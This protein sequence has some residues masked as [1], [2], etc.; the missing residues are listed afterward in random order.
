[1]NQG[2]LLGDG[3]ERKRLG[4]GAHLYTFQRK[5]NILIKQQLFDWVI[6]NLDT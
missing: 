6:E 5:K 4:G 2:R 1:M 3:T